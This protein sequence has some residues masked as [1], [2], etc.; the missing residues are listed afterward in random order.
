MELLNYTST[1]NFIFSD[2]VL[3]KSYFSAI[4]HSFEF[5]WIV[6]RFSFLSFPVF[7]S[8]RPRKSSL[9]VRCAS[10]VVASTKV[11]SATTSKTLNTEEV[12][13]SVSRNNN[14]SGDIFEFEEEGLL[15]KQYQERK[16]SQTF[17]NKLFLIDH[18]Y[19]K[20]FSELF[21]SVE[22]VFPALLAT[23]LLLILE[24]FLTMTSLIETF[25]LLVSRG[26]HYC[27]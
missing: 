6:T 20:M 4:L 19:F 7:L 26:T 15:C 21:L 13:K 8:C 11:K 9:P 27:T 14:R 23:L 3:E 10:T 18:V 25:T 12:V 2:S 24:Q 16:S 22:I 17:G 1:Q 5:Y